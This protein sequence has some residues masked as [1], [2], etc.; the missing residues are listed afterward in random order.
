MWE[1]VYLRDGVWI[2][3]A[4][5]DE[6]DEMPSVGDIMCDTPLAD[7]RHPPATD[8]RIRFVDPDEAREVLGPTAVRQEGLSV[9]LSCKLT[10]RGRL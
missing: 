1:N 8:G 4:S 6:V 5:P 9:S 7:R 10:C 3:V 2:V